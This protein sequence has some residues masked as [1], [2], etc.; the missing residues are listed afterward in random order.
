M[1]ET[2]EFIHGDLLICRR[3][4]KI[5]QQVKRETG[6]A[7]VYA[8]TKSSACRPASFTS[9]SRKQSCIFICFLR[10]TLTV[11]VGTDR[12]VLFTYI[13]SRRKS[14]SSALPEAFCIISLYKSTK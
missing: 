11:V 8:C 10:V 6:F 4:I 13:C 2:G 7:P 9:R 12:T 14:L 5:L 3:V 1:R